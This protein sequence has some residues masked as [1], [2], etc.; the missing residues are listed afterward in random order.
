M[1]LNKQWNYSSLWIRP[2]RECHDVWCHRQPFQMTYM[3]IYFEIHVTL[4]FLF[5]RM[6]WIYFIEF[7]SEHPS[8]IIQ[9]K[10][11]KVLEGKRSV[12]SLHGVWMNKCLNYFLYIWQLNLAVHFKYLIWHHFLDLCDYYLPLL[13][14]ERQ[15]EGRRLNPRANPSIHSV[16]LMHLCVI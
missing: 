2:W 9:L 10:D 6:N 12:W 11:R 3:S 7:L 14:L 16:W 8:W 13:A 15:E 5:V 4:S 1:K